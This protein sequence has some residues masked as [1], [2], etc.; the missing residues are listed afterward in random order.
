MG[1]KGTN[2]QIYMDSAV[3]QKA[4]KIARKSGF[5]NLQDLVRFFLYQVVSGNFIPSVKI[6]Q[7]KNSVTFKKEESVTFEKPGLG[8]DKEDLLITYEPFGTKK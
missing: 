5:D 4:E 8:S 7:P 6:E 3:K 2:F 1:K